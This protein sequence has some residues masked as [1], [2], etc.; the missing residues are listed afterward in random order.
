MKPRVA[1]THRGEPTA[2]A[3]LYSHTAFCPISLHLARRFTHHAL[4]VISAVDLE[5]L[6]GTRNHW[7]WGSPAL[8][9]GW[10]G[11]GGTQQQG[12]RRWV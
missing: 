1:R 12:G 2:A 7:I 5:S 6:L 8:P 10:V 11:L 3:S 9:A 4:L